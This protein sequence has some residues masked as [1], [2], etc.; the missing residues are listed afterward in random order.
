MKILAA[1]L[2]PFSVLADDALGPFDTI[3]SDQVAAEDTYQAIQVTYD[4]GQGVL[5]TRA[6]FRR[7]GA[8][9]PTIELV[10]PAEAQVDGKPVATNVNWVGETNYK[11]STR[12]PLVPRHT[13]SWT[14]QRGRAHVTPVEIRSVRLTNLPATVSRSQGLTLSWTGEDLIDGD[15]INV[16]LYGEGSKLAE[17]RATRTGNRT[18]RVSPEEL[19]KLPAGAVRVSVSRSGGGSLKPRT[20]ATKAGGR[21][22]V[23]YTGADSQVTLAP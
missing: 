4:E 1:L 12:G 2:L 3:R 5:R 17:A 13:L 6:T 16:K 9:G 14:D 21:L 22:S 10:K 8:F 18:I 19:G 7:R 11:T 23:L 15:E 20:G